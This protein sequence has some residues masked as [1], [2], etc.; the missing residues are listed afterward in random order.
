MADRNNTTAIKDAETNWMTWNSKFL[1]RKNKDHAPRR[2][3]TRYCEAIHC[4]EEQLDLELD[5][6][7]F[8]PEEESQ[9]E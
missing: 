6:N 4:D 3:L 8:A 9:E 2:V 1:P 5:W 7:F